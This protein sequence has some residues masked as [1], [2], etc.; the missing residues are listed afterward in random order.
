MESFR[1]EDIHSLLTNLPSLGS[2]KKKRRK[3]KDLD[4]SICRSELLFSPVKETH[5]S[6][7]SLDLDGY[8]DDD[9]IILTCQA[10][11]DNYTI[12]FEGSTFYSDESYCGEFFVI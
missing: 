11:K 1:A 6:V 4:N 9:D 10:N 3:I 8:I 7:D 12:A 2:D 5:I